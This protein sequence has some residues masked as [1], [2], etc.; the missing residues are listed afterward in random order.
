MNVNARIVI[1]LWLMTTMAP[2][3]AAPARLPITRPESVALDGQRLAQIDHLVAEA[4]AERKM[5]GCVVAIGRRGKLAFLKAYGNKQVQPSVVPMTTDTVF[6]LASIT[7]PV[8]TATSIMLLIEQ[9]KLRVT[10]RVAAHLSEFAVNGKEGITVY[11]LLTHQSGLI[12]DNALKDYEDGP[13][14]AI[15]R[16]HALDTVAEPGT[17]FIYSDVNFIV[18]AELVRKLSGQD[19]AKFAAERVFHPL[20][21]TETGYLPRE[22]LRA[23]AAPTEQRDG[24]WMVGEVHDPRAYKLGGVAGHAGLFGT[25]QDLAV[26]ASMMINGGHHGGVRVLSPSTVAMMTAAYPVPNGLRGL[27]WDKRSAFSSN[28]GETMTPR[29]F[30][31][32]GFTG[33]GF[34]IDP[35]FELFVIFLS[36]RVHPEGKGAVNPLIGRIGTVAVEAITD[37]RPSQVGSSTVLTGVDVLQR[38][39]FRALQGQRVGLITNPTGINRDGVRTSRLLHEAPAVKLVA[40]FS[41]EHGADAALDVSKVDDTIDKTTGLKVFSLYGATR[42]PTAEMLAELDTLVFDIQDVGTRFYTYVSTMGNAMQA[43]AEQKK[44]FVV[45]DR[46][47][48][49]NGVDVAGPMLDAGRESFVGFHPLPVR[50]G[51]TVGELALMFKAELKLELELEVVKVEG[52]N[53]ADFFDATGLP[54]INPSP[55]MRSLTQALLYPGIGLL[56]TTNLSVGRG[57]DTPFEVIG[58]PWLDGR[59]LAEALNAAEL[60]GARF[61]PIRFT[62]SSSKFEHQTCGGVNLLITDRVQF[63]PLRVGLEVARQLRRLYAVEWDVKAYDR[64]LC[65]AKT[66]QAVTEGMAVEEMEN[67]WRPALAE[68]I[69]RREQYLAY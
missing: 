36:N 18:L 11:Q 61:V 19:V 46:P 26:Y 44:R 8:A 7:K 38:N 45:L 34:W 3:L 12:A 57:T 50:H 39:H 48:P 65:N 68:F 22:E 20:G 25:A 53:R 9:G 55:N 41:P 58:A 33:I 63:E 16:V 10:D 37:Q 15:A 6:D 14:K 27:G 13:A 42:K 28:R 23:R 1:T 43:A 59:V 4:L 40:L 62:P 24:K 5:P 2:P 47:N 32:G 64:L 60:P 67:S 30:G 49:I 54:W 29:A 66:L 51:M 69:Q 31:H 21:M 56:E 52:W 35:A 17:R